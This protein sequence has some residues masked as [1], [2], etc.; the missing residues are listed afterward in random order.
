MHRIRVRKSGL[1]VGNRKAEKKIR[2]DKY[3]SGKV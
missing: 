3:E 1:S 2:V